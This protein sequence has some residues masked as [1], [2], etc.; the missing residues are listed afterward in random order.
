VAAILRDDPRE[1]V[2]VAVVALRQV[3]QI[4]P[5]AHRMLRVS[6]LLPPRVL[7]SRRRVM[8]AVGRLD[9]YHARICRR[10]RRGSGRGAP[11]EGQGYHTDRYRLGDPPDQG[12]ADDIDN[13]A[14]PAYPSRTARDR[15]RN[16]HDQLQHERQREPS[17][18][19]P[20]EGGDEVDNRLDR[21]FTADEYRPDLRDT[22]HV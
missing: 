21:H 3:P 14:Q 6:T 17:P 1:L 19:E 16:G 2:T 7:A 13:P 20:Q 8:L 22:R 15:L 10:R 12:G 11:R 4:V 5:R 9:D 18:D